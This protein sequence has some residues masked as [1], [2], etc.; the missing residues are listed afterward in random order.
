MVPT[1]FY[2]P[3]FVNGQFEGQAPLADKM[4]N[5]MRP[6]LCR[7]L[8]VRQPGDELYQDKETGCHLVSVLGTSAL[9][10]R[11]ARGARSFAGACARFAGSNDGK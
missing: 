5:L 3:S 10:V 1:E 2:L 7:L 4:M 9:L 11:R 6:R 8:I